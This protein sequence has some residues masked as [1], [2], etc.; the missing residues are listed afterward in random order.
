MDCVWKTSLCPEGPNCRR[1][2][3]CNFAHSEHELRVP[4]RYYGQADGYKK[5]VCSDLALKIDGG[6]RLGAK[7]FHAHSSLEQRKPNVSKWSKKG[8]SFSDAHCHM[9]AVL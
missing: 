3:D 7:C 9:D 6:C 5:M 1:S 2:D 8:P 4:R